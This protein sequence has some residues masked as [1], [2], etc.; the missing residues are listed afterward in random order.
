[1]SWLVQGTA[2][3]LEELERKVCIALGEALRMQGLHLITN[4]AAMTLSLSVRLVL[5]GNLE[6][7]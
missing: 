7:I 2:R 3:G 5:M 4:L 6:V 1:M